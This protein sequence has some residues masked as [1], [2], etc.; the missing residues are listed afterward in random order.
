[1]TDSTPE[2]PSWGQFLKRALKPLLIFIVVLGIGQSVRL[3]WN[4]L[5]TTQ[6]KAYERIISLQKQVVDASP[7]KK[8]TIEIEIMAIEKSLFSLRKIRWGIASWSIVFAFLALLPAAFYWWLTLRCFGYPVPAVAT[9]A[10]YA[11]GILGKYVPGKAMV[12]ILRS[13]AMQQ[14]G[15]PISTTI[16]SIFIETF[17]SL[18]VGGALGAITV[19]ALQPPTW[20][21]WT[22]VCVAVIALVPTIPPFFRRALEILTRYRHLR[23]PKKLASAM[24]WRLVASGWI[25]FF[26]SWILMG[27]SLWVLCEAIRNSMNAD[28]TDVAITTVSSLRLW[29]IC[30]SATCIGFVIG[31]VSMLP[32][33][34]GVR[35]VVVTMLLAPVIGYAPALAA[36][37][38]YRIVNL[39]AELLLTGVTWLL[40]R[41]V[42]K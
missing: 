35:E 37:V 1:M 29:W 19:T 27:S 23:I 5:Q 26:I 36:A 24:S 31:F 7:G 38:L 28:S 21:F 30:V 20:L 10:S 14:F 12:L 15:V 6:T 22:A 25:L 11:S 39:V 2:R 32:G 42:T 41:T 17:T 34:A 8:A 33:G 16:V 3:A 4:D 18:A 9:F 40:N 13:G